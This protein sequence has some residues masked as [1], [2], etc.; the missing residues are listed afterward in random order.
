MAR[1][2]YLKDYRIVETLNERGGIRTSSE[3]VG[4]PYR[5]RDPQAA[6]GMKKLLPG[7]CILSW[8][9]FIAALLPDSAASR[10]VYVSI[11]FLFAAIPLGM[12]TERAITLLR[13]RLPLEHRSADR[14]N[15]WIGGGSL[16]TALLSGISLAGELISFCI[17]GRDFTWG[18]AVFAAG[19]LILLCCGLVL[20]R[21]RDRLQTEP[22]S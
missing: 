16:M 7:L 3:Y 5:F 18:D 6:E 11:P 9:A 1:R 19:A 14:Y 20:R 21:G 17:G 15:N 22:E 12:L 2:K 10:T 8:L 13:G 4:R